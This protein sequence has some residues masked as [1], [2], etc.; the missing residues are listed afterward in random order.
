MMGLAAHLLTLL[1]LM[2]LVGADVTTAP[3]RASGG[4]VHVVAIGHNTGRAGEVPLRF[5]ERDAS[6]L[7]QVFRQLGGARGDTSALSLGESAERV[8]D[9]L[10]RTNRRIRGADG[11]STLI[12]FYSGHADAGGLHLGPTTLPYDEL[13]A[14]VAGSPATVRILIIDACRSGGV[15]RVKG[16]SDAPSFEIRVAPAPDAEGLAVIT[17]S[18]ADEDS[19]ESEALRASFFSHH[20][21]AGLRGAADRDGDERVTLDEAYAHAYRQTLRSSGRTRSLQHP[22]Y[23]F[24]MRGRGQVTLTRLGSQSDEV[25]RLALDAPGLWMVMQ[26]SEDGVVVADTVVEG[27]GATLVLPPRPYLV[28]HRRDTDMRQFR[29]RLAPGATRP[30][31]SEPFETIGYARLVRKGAAVR[32]FAFALALGAGVR[33]PTL[34]GERLVGQL[35]LSLTADL[36]AASLGLRV[37]GAWPS[38]RATSENVDITQSELSIGVSAIRFLDLGLW[39][40]GLGVL[41]EGTWIGQRL[42][43]E[44]ALPSR[45][46]WAA[47]FGL[48]FAVQWEVAANLGLYVEGGPMARVFRQATLEGGAPTGEVLVTPVTGWVTGGALWRF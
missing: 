23:R 42:S 35:V 43:G 20:L 39:S 40:L 4:D 28:Q 15:T 48:L 16:F 22:T 26:D 30:L 47:G 31:A 36:N 3:A 34:P 38:T 11:P 12:V 29:V 44:K 27:R 14:L 17:S 2:A 21:I 7:L 9:L 37:T 24:D 46:A 32:P 19:H 41:V 6:E 1:A 45:D 18:T 33:G 8:R 5:A 25:G 10:L 13:E